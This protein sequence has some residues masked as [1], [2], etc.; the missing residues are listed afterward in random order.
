[1]IPLRVSDIR[2]GSH[3]RLVSRRALIGLGIGILLGFNI[4]SYIAIP[5]PNRTDIEIA[6]IAR[7]GAEGLEGMAGGLT[8]FRVGAAR[9]RRQKGVGSLHIGKGCKHEVIAYESADVKPLSQKR[10][11]R[12]NER[13]QANQNSKS[14][15]EGGAL[16]DGFDLEQERLKRQKE[17]EVFYESDIEN[18]DGDA[19][20]GGG[21]EEFQLPRNFEKYVDYESDVNAQNSDSID[22]EHNGDVRDSDQMLADEVHRKLHKPL[23]DRNHFLYIGVLTAQKYLATRGR[24]IHH[25][26]EPHV[27]GKVE[28]YV[29]EGVEEINAEKKDPLPLVN[30]QSVQDDV[31]PPQK[32]SFLL[33]KRMYDSYLNSGY[34]WFMR[35]DDD[36]Y[37]N[38]H[39]LE[40]F[41]RRLNS[42]EPIYLGQTGLGNAEERGRLSLLHGENYCMGGPGMI[43]SRE[44]LRRIG[45][46]IRECVHH[47]YSWHEDVEIS[48][49]VRKFAG[50]NCAWSYQMQELFYEHY[51]LRKGY[52]DPY[53]EPNNPKFRTAMTLHPN[54]NPAY[55]VKL[56]QFMRSQRL[57]QRMMD[58]KRLSRDVVNMD[59]YLGSGSDIEDFMLGSPLT[60]NRFM[61]RQHSE[62]LHWNFITD[63]L[64]Y[65]TPPHQPRR[66]TPNDW[67]MTI[68]S[69][70]MQVMAMMN[71][72]SRVRGRVIDFKQV[73]YGYRRV[74]P[75]YGAEYVLDLLLIYKRYK[76]KKMT[77]PVRRHAYLQ[78][79]F[80]RTDMYENSP[81][82]KDEIKRILRGSSA[83]MLLSFMNSLVNKSK[84]ILS[85]MGLAGGRS[86]VAE[87]SKPIDID[88]ES[89]QRK[90]SKVQYDTGSFRVFPQDAKSQANVETV[91][92][93][94]PLSGRYDTF[95][96][97]MSNLENVSLSRGDPI[98]LM[99]VVF[100]GVD[101]E[102]KE[103]GIK[104]RDLLDSYSKRYPLYDMRQIPIN[105][106][107]SR[108][109]ALEIGASHFSNDSLLFFCDVDVVFDNEFTRK[110]RS[111]TDLGKRVFYPVLFSEFHP[112]FNGAD[113]SWKFTSDD[114]DARNVVKPRE[115]HYELTENTGHWRSYGYGLL[116]VYQKDFTETGGFDMTIQGW[117][118]ED[119]DLI[120]KFLGSKHKKKADALT[121][122]EAA[123]K[124]KNMEI[125]RVSEPSLVHVY[126][127]SHCDPNLMENQ[128]RMCQASRASGITST[129]NLNRMWQL[130]GLN[131]TASAVADPVSGIVPVL[132]HD[133]AKE[134]LRE[135]GIENFSDRRERAL[136]IERRTLKLKQNRKFNRNGIR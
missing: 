68:R 42:S 30:L 36:V 18:D 82:D 52:I 34:Q 84:T 88:K 58:I 87:S 80:G 125:M 12:R 45:P 76:G 31:Y 6:V 62:V 59:G 43:F 100:I 50:V 16:P 74:N 99:A 5:T 46:H 75:L 114:I 103:E 130:L 7:N 3:R 124:T 26:W 17:L 39:K 65:S 126:H 90:E 115:N 66:S 71:S 4:A 127:P 96:S 112:R 56:H 27:P 102:Y 37:I 121:K 10:M 134:Q 98:S 93:I 35:A 122:D 57:K 107:F 110:C 111:N 67:Q 61:P 21:F 9:I 117:G 19:K 44:V 51:T 11:Q 73:G 64:L 120:D 123:A 24:A 77:I 116:C 131:R 29:G 41:L 55:Q 106:K 92:I 2:M 69:I 133:V 8:E 25:T 63:H 105:A 101:S 129:Y 33:L 13:M 118:L 40:L 32:K 20:N 89:I 79:S 22:G 70:V 81:I 109:L 91:N 78:Q 72:N 85:V 108:G 94:V 119:V 83:N 135:R 54:K 48:R 60:L 95:R 53:E 47:L 86:P 113:T 14:L 132:P 97:F 128:L 1:M 104:T 15:K 28:F 23:T 49:C 136:E 38:T